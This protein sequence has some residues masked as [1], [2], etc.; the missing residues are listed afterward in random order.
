MKSILKNI[1]YL[2]LFA[3]FPLFLSGCFDFVEEIH[4]N[5]DG[6]GNV[7][8]KLNISKSKT[9]LGSIMLMDSI[10]GFAVPDEDDLHKKLVSLKSHLTEQ[11]GLRN[12]QLKENWDDFIFEIRFDF[13]SVA[14][15]NDGFESAMSKDKHAKSFF[16]A[17]FDAS[18]NRFKRNYI[19]QD[20]SALNGWNNNFIEVFEN[21]NFIAVYRFDKIVESQ[22][23]SNYL[24]SKNGKAVMFKA[25]FLD[26]IKKRSTLLNT[27]TLK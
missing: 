23:N 7:K 15:I 12:V 27:I 6:T 24:R 2:L 11:Q 5:E 3:S 26:L 18:E 19:H 14:A 17:P 20:Y 22:S 25:S 16:F 8:Y 21:S 10:K 1:K 9:K 13:D 4:L